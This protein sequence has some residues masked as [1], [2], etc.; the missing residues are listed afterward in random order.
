MTDQAA[1]FKS[2]DAFKTISEVST[3]LDIP[4]HV[5]RF[6]ETKFSQVKPMKRAGGRRYYR[7]S[8]I[9]LLGA[10]RTLLYDDGYTIRG[11]QKILREKGVRFLVGEKI[12]DNEN[13]NN[14]HFIAKASALT[15]TD[16]SD[17]LI[18]K[19]DVH[20]ELSEILKELCSLESEL[21]Q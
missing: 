8:D 17:T 14:E 5:L 7:P 1:D 20:R 4:Q 19:A 11:V 2:G 6:W 15:K 21:R 10:I 18:V 9:V 12:A 3:S 16:T 13:D